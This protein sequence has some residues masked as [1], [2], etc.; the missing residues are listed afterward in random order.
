MAPD[1]RHGGYMSR[2]PAGF[3]VFGHNRTFSDN[4]L[5]ASS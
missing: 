3:C 5:P 1:E 4:K 2:T